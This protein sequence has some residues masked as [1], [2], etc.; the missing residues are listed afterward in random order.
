M[1]GGVPADWVL[2]MKELDKEIALELV[3][4]VLDELSGRKGLDVEEII[5]DDE[6]YQ[7]LIDTMV[8]RVGAILRKYYV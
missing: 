5:Q 2:L 1:V 6:I 7:D 3:E 8:E 4:H